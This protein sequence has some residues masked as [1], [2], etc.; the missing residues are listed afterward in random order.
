MHF[1]TP[2]ACPVVAEITFDHGNRDRKRIEDLVIILAKV[3]LPAR[4]VRFMHHGPGCPVIKFGLYLFQPL[5]DH[6]FK[7]YIDIGRADILAIHNRKLSQLG[8]APRQLQQP[9]D[10]PDLSFR[11]QHRI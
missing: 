5:L 8:A 7:C 4:E 3:T 2:N 11:H 1:T 9:R 6:L 10:R